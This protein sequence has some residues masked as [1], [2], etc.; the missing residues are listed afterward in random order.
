MPS[1]NSLASIKQPP[2]DKS[3]YV[4]TLPA[5]AAGE[6]QADAKHANAKKNIGRPRLDEN[7]RRDYKITLSITQAQGQKIKNKAGLAGEATYLYDLLEKA[8]AFE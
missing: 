4:P 1:K 7:Q 6:A 3:D 8:D 2:K 5:N